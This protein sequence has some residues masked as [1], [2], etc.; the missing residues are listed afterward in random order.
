MISSVFLFPYYLV[1]KIRHSLYD[2]GRIA[3]VQHP[4]P[5]VSVGNVTAGGTGKTPMVEYLAN[6]L[7]GSHRVAVLSRGYKRKFPDIRVA[8]DK[9]CNH[10]VQQLLALP[11]TDMPRSIWKLHRNLLLT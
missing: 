6:L 4:V 5:V 11:S 2:K 7:R 1:L 3:S 9:D 8:V 10:G